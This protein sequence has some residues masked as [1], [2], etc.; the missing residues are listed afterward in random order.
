MAVY[1]YLRRDL[2]EPTEGELV[3]AVLQWNKAFT[4]DWM[5]YRLGMKEIATSAW[6]LP[7]VRDISG[8]ADDDYVLPIDD[9]D[10]HH[11]D[12]ES[13]LADKHQ[14]V[15]WW[16]SVVNFV[17]RQAGVWNEHVVTTHSMRYP[18][19]SG[20]ALRVSVLRNNPNSSTL[21]GGHHMVAKLVDM[22]RLT[23]LKT[24]RQLAVYTRHPGSILSLRL[25]WRNIRQLI[26]RSYI[27]APE[28]ALWMEPQ[29]S[30]VK[31]LVKSLLPRMFL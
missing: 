12:V 7:V 18:A 14:D 31:C 1:I 8:L 26:P 17:M 23:M 5:S 30:Q 16:E 29:F 24:E 28:W 25:P 15:I 2:Y 19:S 20:Y 9:D 27:D 10:W 3:D 6:R 22:S 21:L 13:F 11:P 4:I